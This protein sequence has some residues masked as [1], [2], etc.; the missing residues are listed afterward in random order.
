[1]EPPNEGERGADEA[2]VT[3]KPRESERGRGFESL[4]IIDLYP[5]ITCSWTNYSSRLDCT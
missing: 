1:M 2:W 3:L 4:L 5:G